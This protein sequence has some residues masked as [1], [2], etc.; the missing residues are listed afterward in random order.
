M[1]PNF[2]Y[3]GRWLQYNDD[4]HLVTLKNLYNAKN[5]WGQLCCFLARHHAP[6]K[7]MAKFYLA[8]IQ[9]ILLYGS[10]TWTL[11]Q[12]QLQLLETFHH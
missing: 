6:V 12:Q 11:T 2:K 4:D 5:K 7:T 9:A 1:V 8:S 10:E 3:L